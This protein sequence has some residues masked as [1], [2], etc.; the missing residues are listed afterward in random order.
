MHNL[1]SA[2]SFSNIFFEKIAF[3]LVFRVLC[4][5]QLS[6]SLFLTACASKVLFYS[7]VLIKSKTFHFPL[8]K[9]AANNA[10]KSI[11]QV[12]WT[13]VFFVFTSSTCSKFLE[14]SQYCYG[15]S[16]I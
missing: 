12:D 4:F 7:V 13:Q 16:I 2:H 14:F 6:E 5:G 9:I 3:P 15:T 11:G 10:K 1:S 8:V